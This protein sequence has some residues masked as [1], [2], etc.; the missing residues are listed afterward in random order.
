MGEGK[1]KKEKTFQDLAAAA[2]PKTCVCHQAVSGRLGHYSN[3]LQQNND[4]E[5]LGLTLGQ[6]RLL[7]KWRDTLNTP[8]GGACKKSQSGAECGLGLPPPI[9]DR[10]R[11]DWATGT[12][13]AP[14]TA[15]TATLNQD[16]D[17]TDLMKSLQLGV[18]DELW[19]DATVPRPQGTLKPA[20]LI[21]DFVTRAIQRTGDD[22]L[23]RE[24]C[25][26]GGAQLVL[27]QARIKPLA[28]QMS[29]A[30]YLS[31]RRD[32]GSSHPRG[33]AKDGGHSGLPQ[34]HGGHW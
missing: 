26:Q 12:A 30:Q 23:E 11:M 6:K 27:R 18:G 16:R 9:M 33:Q 2:G 5:S 24:V 1:E 10:E 4:F 13:K 25:K 17:L 7:Q 32:Y 28:E 8:R 31:K 14:E 22:S 29:L 34:V 15:T 20:L 21:P 3:K 19:E